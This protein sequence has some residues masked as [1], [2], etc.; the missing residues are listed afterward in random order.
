M[1]PNQ[2]VLAQ[3]ALKFNYDQT[4]DHFLGTKK[5]FKMKQNTRASTSVI[6]QM[7]NI[8]LDPRLNAQSISH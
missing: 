7:A 2:R 1:H 3:V 4:L 5:G 6:A 8:I